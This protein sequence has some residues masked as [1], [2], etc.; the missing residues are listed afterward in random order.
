MFNHERELGAIAADSDRQFDFA[1]VHFVCLLEIPS[2]SLVFVIYRHNHY[3]KKRSSRAYALSLFFVPEDEGLTL[4]IPPTRLMLR[5]LNK[6]NHLLMSI[7]LI[8]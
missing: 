3:D 8:Y 1:H 4:Q 7:H 6:S 2:A 5:H